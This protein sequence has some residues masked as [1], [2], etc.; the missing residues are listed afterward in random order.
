[1]K[2]SVF[3]EAVEHDYACI[4]AAPLFLSTVFINSALQIIVI[5]IKLRV[6]YYVY[7]VGCAEGVG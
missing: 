5:I 4:S 2:L 1:M 3:D 7:C 6:N